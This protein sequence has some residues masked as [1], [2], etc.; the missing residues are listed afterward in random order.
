MVAA[1][2]CTR[3]IVNTISTVDMWIT[4]WIVCGRTVIHRCVN[5]DK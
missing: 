4:I 5:V 1:I 2:T 3:G